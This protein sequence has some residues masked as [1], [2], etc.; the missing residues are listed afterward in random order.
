MT[1]VERQCSPPLETAQSQLLVVMPD[2]VLFRR[3]IRPLLRILCNHSSSTAE[4]GH[5]TSLRGE[6]L[7]ATL[8]PSRGH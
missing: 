3:I 5:P 6:M 1:Y 2:C 4:C 7:V 8:V